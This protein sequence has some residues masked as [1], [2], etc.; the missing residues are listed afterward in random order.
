M[1]TSL[2]IARLARLILVV[3]GF[4]APRKPLGGQHDLSKNAFGPLD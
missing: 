4:A 3:A 2:F 1:E